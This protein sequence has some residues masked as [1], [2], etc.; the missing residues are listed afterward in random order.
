MRFEFELLRHTGARWTGILVLCLGMAASSWA[1]QPSAADQAT[2][3]TLVGLMS[4]GQFAQVHRYFNRNLQQAEPASKLKTDWQSVVAEYGVF[5]KQLAVGGEDVP[6]YDIVNVKCSF[7]YAP[8]II[9]LVFTKHH[10][11]GGLFFV[12]DLKTGS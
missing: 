10:R 12:P 7:Q 2:A 5:Q 6:G 8:V 11:V 1:T 4:Q 9:R 3:K